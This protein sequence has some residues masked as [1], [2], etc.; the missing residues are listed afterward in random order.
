VTGSSTDAP[1]NKAEPSTSR[2]VAMAVT[3]PQS[4]IIYY[5]GYLNVLDI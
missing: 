4:E 1:M 2:P 3:S 5:I